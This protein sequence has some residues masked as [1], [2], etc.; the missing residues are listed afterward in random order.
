MPT[1]LYAENLAEHNLKDR[2]DFALHDY[3]DQGGACDLILSVG[4]LEHISPADVF[5]YF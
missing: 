1:R 2:L 3:C 4:I 5:A